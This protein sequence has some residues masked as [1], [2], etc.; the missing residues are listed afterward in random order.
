MPKV[1][2][3]G[4]SVPINETT[5]RGKSVTSGQGRAVGEKNTTVT[6]DFKQFKLPLGTETASNWTP[7]GNIRDSARSNTDSIVKE[8]EKV[9]KFTADEIRA[10]IEISSQEQEIKKK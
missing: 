10:S 9:T 2:S 8:I 3:F 7:R 1:C 5:P 4:H 6:I